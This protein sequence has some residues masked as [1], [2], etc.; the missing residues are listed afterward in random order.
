M[1]QTNHATAAVSAEEA[2]AAIN[3]QAD[4]ERFDGKRSD[5]K[6]FG[7]M[8]FDDKNFDGSLSDDARPAAARRRWAPSLPLKI[9]L[10]LGVLTLASILF[11]VMQDI[12]STRGS[13]RE[14]MQGSN[15][16]ATQLL[17]RVAE[18]QGRAGLGQLA[19]F[20]R[21]TG[22]VRANEIML[23]D[24][25]GQLVYTSPPST[26]K[27]GRDAP[28]WYAALVTPTLRATVIRLPA[29]TLVVAPNPSRAVLD[30]WD[31]LRSFALGQLGLLCLAYLVT[32]WTLRRWLAPF[33]QIRRALRE[34]GQ[35]RQ[36]RLP[37]LPGRESA[38]LGQAVNSMAHALQES[39]RARQE[40]AE[41][42][43]RLA[44]QRDFAHAMRERV[45]DERRA[46]A[47]E[48]HDEF[49]QSLT[50][51]RS[52]AAALLQHPDIRGRSAENAMRLLFDT[53]GS[54]LD[55]MHRLIPRL[56]PAQLDDAGLGEALRDL[57]ATLRLAHPELHI[58]LAMHALPALDPELETAA[59]R[60]AQ[61]ALTNVVRHAYAT[62]ATIALGVEDASL[63]LRIDDNG[64]GGAV[65]A[66][67]ARF[68]VRGMKERAEAL[69]GTLAL[70]SSETGGVSV[71]ARLPIRHG[72]APAKGTAI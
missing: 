22:R 6:G 21:Q 63:V 33:E 4:D 67:S 49:G 10:I 3:K 41:A 72:A 65:N 52:I 15:R 45:E 55:G 47:R 59:Y 71:V 9:G 16:V 5:D 53:A 29:G 34:I 8:G 30:A 14:E 1:N 37:A 56:R 39:M 11:F 18:A 54:T 58:E 24:N 17:S 68:G 43:A 26:Y 36:V 2:D 62:S 61:E 46:I 32:Y 42:R 25:R 51:I 48:L 66:S 31:D 35:G 50:A 57:A 70:G 7:N 12:D 20:L 40:S 38:E 60:I 13:I 19:L 27:S 44:A 28:D 23:Y 64:R 69:D